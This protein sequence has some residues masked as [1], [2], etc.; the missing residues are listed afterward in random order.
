MFGDLGVPEVL[1][2]LGIA[3]LIFGPH[4]L[5]DLGKGLGQGIK[6]FKSAFRDPAPEPKKEEKKE[7]TA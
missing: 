6:E 7:I 3:L 4:K 2:I 1:F 5:G